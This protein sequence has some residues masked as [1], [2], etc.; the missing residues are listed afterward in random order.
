MGIP[1][2]TPYKDVEHRHLKTKL[3]E[4]EIESFR[5]PHN[6]CENRNFLISADGQLIC[7]LVDLEYCPY[8]LSELPIDT[9]LVECNYIEDLVDDDIPNL[10]HKVLGHCSLETSLEIIKECKKHLRNVFL[11]HASKGET[12]D[13]ERA[14]NRIREEIP[15]YINVEFLRDNTVRDI[16]LCPF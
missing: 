2:Y 5:V 12:M 4:F 14:I 16:S 1:T 15:A 7:F 9:L 11:I 3:G 8:D 6:G 10:R 13:R